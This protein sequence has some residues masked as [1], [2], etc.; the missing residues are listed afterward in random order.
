LASC[1]VLN[2]SRATRGGTPPPLSPALQL[3]KRVGTLDGVT[4][5]PRSSDRYRSFA[6]SGI[7]VGTDL[8]EVQAVADSINTFGD[9]YIRR[10]YTDHE[11]DYCTGD[12]QHE[13][14]RF[15]ARFAAKEAVVK[16][17][18]PT[19]VRPDWRSIEVR[20]DRQ[21]WCEINLCDLAD[22]LAMKAGITAL[23]VSLSHD[24]AYASAVVVAQLADAT[25]PAGDS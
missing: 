10:V 6:A 22:E 11:I 12:P 24:G 3:R 14:E 13:A 16:V 18:R 9:R 4:D 17:L 23:A 7:R 21:G 1:D 2:S 5:E 19:D 25:A 8:T 15:A 20:R